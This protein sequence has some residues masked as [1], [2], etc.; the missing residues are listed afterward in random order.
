[1]LAYVVRR[2]LL[3]IPTIF[4]IMLA[5]FVIIQAAPG[6]PVEQV[7]AQ[8]RG[9]AVEATAR[10][11]IHPTTLQPTI[12]WTDVDFAVHGPYVGGT[13]IGLGPTYLAAWALPL[14]FPA[15]RLIL[16]GAA[17]LTGVSVGAVNVI[18]GF[19]TIGSLLEIG[20][21]FLHDAVMLAALDLL[22]HH[23]DDILSAFVPDD[24]DGRVD[25]MIASLLP[26]LPSTFY[27]PVEY[28]YRYIE[29]QLDQA[30]ETAALTA[31]HRDAGTDALGCYG[32][33]KTFT[34]SS[35]SAPALDDYFGQQW[36]L[37]GGVQK[38]CRT[39]S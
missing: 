1:M 4:G 30:R 31:F 17:A 27:S 33:D 8:L 5:N 39:D 32:T 11:A 19:N 38:G 15:L 36:R 21:L 14:A 6:G 29:Q 20:Q 18:L 37:G 13:H 16:W 22:N 3:M 34:A 24:V 7:V 10:I 23:T 28:F 35:G 25:G 26:P 9:H 12:T 2:L